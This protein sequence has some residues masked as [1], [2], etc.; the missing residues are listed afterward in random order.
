M[1]S[2]AIAAAPAAVY[3]YLSDASNLPAW[4]PGF[5]PRVRPQG[6][7]W[8]VGRGDLEFTIEVL[9][10]PRS[11]TVD[12]VA[13]GDHARGLFARVLPNGDGSELVFAITFT[14]DTPEEVVAAQ[15]LTLETELAAVRDA[16][17]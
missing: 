16:C 8:L 9:A 3:A 10:E 15:M 11:R 14:P 4:A 6:A 17:E 1:R 12:F 5:A 7:R 2:L 13:P